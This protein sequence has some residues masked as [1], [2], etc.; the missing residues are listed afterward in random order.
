MLFFMAFNFYILDPI[1]F[2]DAKR[3]SHYITALVVTF[4]MFACEKHAVQL[5]EMVSYNK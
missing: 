3:G 4:S 2:R 5:S 1:A